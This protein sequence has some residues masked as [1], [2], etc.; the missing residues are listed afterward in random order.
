MRDGTSLALEK[1][2][3]NARRII[4]FLTNGCLTILALFSYSGGV[5]AA[6]VVPNDPYYSYQTALTAAVPV[7]ASISRAWDIT[8]DASQV[9]VAVI[10]TGVDL[11]HP[12]L[13]DNFWINSGEVEGDGIDNDGNGY[14]DDVH[15]YDFRHRDGNPEDEWG[16]GT[17]I[18]GIIGAQ[19]NNGVGTSGV[20]WHVQMMELKV[21]GASGGARL[22]DYVGAVRYAVANGANIINASWIIPPQSGDPEIESLKAAIEEAQNAGVIVMAAAGNNAQDL[23]QNPLYP[24]SY[25]EYLSNVVSVGGLGLEGDLWAGSNYG[26]HS[27]TLF[28]AAEDVVGTYLDGY[29]AT[30]TGTSAAAAIVSGVVSLMLAQKPELSPSE[31]VEDMIHHGIYSDEMVG[32]SVSASVLDPLAALLSIG[33]TTDETGGGETTGTVEIAS[34]GG[35]HSSTLSASSAGCSLII[36]D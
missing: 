31:I 1:G 15:G 4:G 25:S 36:A 32:K 21:F 17:L 8:T 28:A 26:E 9:I 16:H 18:S 30:L 7:E 12:D 5:H 27:V 35:G 34:A 11:E 33:E 10:D 6:T 24:A 20:A 3:R 19:G 22:E 2:M 14:V 13:V 23:D 29:Y